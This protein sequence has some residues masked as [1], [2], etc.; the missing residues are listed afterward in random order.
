METKGLKIVDDSDK[1][2]TII[3]YIFLKQATIEN[4]C[5][6][7]PKTLNEI[8]RE[9]D[10]ILS[11]KDDFIV[12]INTNEKLTGVAILFNEPSEKYL[13]CLGGFFNDESDFQL[14]MRYFEKK[15]KG[16]HIDFVFPLENV[17]MLKYLNNINGQFEKP[18][19]CMEVI[20][21]EFIKRN[22]PYKIFE[23]TEEY[24]DFYFEIHNDQNIYWTAKRVIEASEIFKAFILFIEGDI[25]GY[26]DVTYDKEITEIYN[27]HAQ[28][29]NIEYMGALINV[30]T[31]NVLNKKNKLIALVDFENIEIINLYKNFGFK[32]L[33][34][35]QTISINI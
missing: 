3:E 30:A 6:L 27:L 1:I 29:E 15:Y 35:S 34:S 19:I 13:E 9:I 11:H 24:H 25:A 14:M 7:F 32:E 33:Y 22:Y 21:D 18:D 31:A 17:N 4:T 28:N 16:N 5:N 12:S 20:F 23:L 2:D 10:K 8:C 26:I